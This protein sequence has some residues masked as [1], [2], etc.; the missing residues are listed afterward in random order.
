M[1]KI[2]KVSYK[3]NDMV[4]M[5]SIMLAYS[6][7][8]FVDVSLFT[9]CVVICT[10]SCNIEVFDPEGFVRAVGMSVHVYV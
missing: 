1:L 9:V 2:Y 5:D 3:Y 7:L 10:Q 8:K 6:S 4:M